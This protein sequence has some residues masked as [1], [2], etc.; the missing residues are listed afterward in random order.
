MAFFKKIWAGL[1]STSVL[2]IAI[3]LSVVAAL[4]VATTTLWINEIFTLWVPVGIFVVL[5]CAFVAIHAKPIIT[6]SIEYF[7]KVHAATKPKDF[8]FFRALRATT[9]KAYIIKLAI[10]V[11]VFLLAILFWWPLIWVAVIIVCVFMVLE[12]SVKSITYIFFFVSFSFSLTVQIYI[13]LVLL[14]V[15][16]LFR[17]IFKTTWQEKK[18]SLVLAIGT[19]LFLVYCSATLVTGV[20]SLMALGYF[21]GL[22]LHMLLLFCVCCLKKEI[23]FKVLV[24][25]FIAGILTATLIGVFVDVISE[26]TKIIE[27]RSYGLTRFSALTENPNHL[28]WLVFAGISGLFVLDLRKQISKKEFIPLFV[29]LFA[30]GL[31]TIARAFILIMLIVVVVYIGL[32]IWRDRKSALKPILVFVTTMLLVCGAM[33]PYTMVNLMRL[34]NVPDNALHEIIR[35]EHPPRHIQHGIDPN[36]SRFGPG[37]HDPG[38]TEIWERNMD[39]WISSPIVFLFGR[40]IAS[41]DIGQVHPHNIV[42]WVLIKIGLVGMLLFILYLLSFFYT[43]FKVKK[44]KFDLVSFLFLIA[45]FGVGMLSL[46]IARI[47]GFVY[48]FFFIFSLQKKEAP[49]EIQ[50]ETPAEIPLPVHKPNKN[51]SAETSI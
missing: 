12:A 31:S 17:Y 19:L 26:L 37:F 40:G 44:Y 45:F 5:I 23:N 43:M 46:I 25:F 33:F 6:V 27:F 38:R 10:C 42:V 18:K 3:K 16:S 15:I 29:L 48:I 20:S 51:K 35:R 8:S 32:S 4:L 50:E 24:Y 49:A 36:S 39:D 34:T 2:G 13:F 47:E 7:K 11:G 9:V 30:I 14:T 22:L 41:P 1:R 21:L 28:Y